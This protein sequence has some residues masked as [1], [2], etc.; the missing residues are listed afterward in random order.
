MEAAPG[1]P[2]HPLDAAALAR[3]VAELGAERLAGALDDP[4]RPA[5]EL[6]ELAGLR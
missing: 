1:S 5:A 4:E 3:K 6:A 2:E